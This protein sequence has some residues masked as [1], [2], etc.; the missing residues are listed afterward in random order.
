M[1]KRHNFTYGGRSLNRATI[2]KD[3][4][5]AVTVELTRNEEADDEENE[6]VARRLKHEATAIRRISAELLPLCEDIAGD[7]LPVSRVRELAGDLLAAGPRDPL[8]AVEVRGTVKRTRGAWTHVYYTGYTQQEAPAP[9]RFSVDETG[10]PVDMDIAVD[11]IVPAHR[12][13]A[14]DDLTV[15]DFRY[16]F[17]HPLMHGASQLDLAI[18]NAGAL[19][20]RGVWEKAVIYAYTREAADRRPLS[21]LRWILESVDRE[22][23]L[24]AGDPLPGPGPFVIYR[25]IAN[26]RRVS[27]PSWTSNLTLAA[28]FAAIA[29]GRDPAVYVTTVPAADVFFYKFNNE[30]VTEYPDVVGDHFLAIVDPEAVERVDTAEVRELISQFR[31]PPESEDEAKERAGEYLDSVV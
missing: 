8:L 14:I 30:C 22:R 18:K 29:P 27:G 21:S 9:F 20:K 2:Q 4:I 25:G 3:N 1:K 17:R 19:Q 7:D 26:G 10:E 28:I 23:L 13:S 24:E 16:F 6:H 5:P 15:G 11:L 31:R 12:A